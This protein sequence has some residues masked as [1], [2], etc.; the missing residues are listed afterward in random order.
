MAVRPV[1]IGNFGPPTLACI[2]SWGEKGC[3]V[4]FVCIAP[5]SAPIPK[6][7][8]LESVVILPPEQ[9][10]KLQGLEIIEKYLREFGATGL[11]AISE[12]IACWLYENQEVLPDSV[13]MWMNTPEALR[14]LLSKKNQIAI[15]REVGFDVLPTYLISTAADIQGISGKDYPLCLRPSD[16][17]TVIPAFKVEYLENESGFMKLINNLTKFEKPIVAQPFLMLPNLNIHA[18]RSASGELLGTQSFLV[19]RKFKGVSLTFEPYRIDAEFFQK[20]SS[21]AEK[22]AV[23]GPFDIEF[24]YDKKKDKIYFIE[25]NNRFGGATAKAFACGY[26]EPY[27]ALKSYGVDCGV[28]RKIKNVVVASRQALVKCTLA[29]INK[30]LTPFDYPSE[31]AINRISFLLKSFIT[32]HDDVFSFADLKGSISL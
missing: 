30:T 10:F 14:N 8:H 4:G 32:H 17:G 31:N 16:A 22:L 21:L 29:T 1:I 9:R 24:L 25:L 3:K 2:R 27:Y 26:D 28:P 6:S 20:C 7:K 12:E 11:M 23:Q 13:G 5:P 15:A 19:R 18:S